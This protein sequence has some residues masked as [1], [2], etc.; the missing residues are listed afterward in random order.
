MGLAH[1]SVTHY[2]DLYSQRRLYAVKLS[3]SYSKSGSELRSSRGFRHRRVGLLDGK[4]VSQILR[5]DDRYVAPDS[6]ISG[7]PYVEEDGYNRDSWNQ[8]YD[9]EK[10]YGDDT[11]RSYATATKWVLPETILKHIR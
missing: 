5:Q 2:V 6:Y 8:N 10:R 3:K 9:R 4:R 7:N 11:D 1:P